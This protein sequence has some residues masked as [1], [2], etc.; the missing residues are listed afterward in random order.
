MSEKQTLDTTYN[1]RTVED[2]WYQYWEEQGYFHP[3][4]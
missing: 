2:K 1:P 3:R 4:S